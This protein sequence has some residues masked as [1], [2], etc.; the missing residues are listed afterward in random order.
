MSSSFPD[1]ASALPAIKADSPNSSHTHTDTG[2][3]QALSQHAAAP[4]HELH[5]N[6][7]AQILFC[8]GKANTSQKLQD[9]MQFS[10][11]RQQSIRLP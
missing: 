4:L 2:L 3:P 6:L 7:T 10:K 8:W 9:A 1:P 5:E 11:P